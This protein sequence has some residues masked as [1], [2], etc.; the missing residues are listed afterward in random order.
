M[1]SF[2]FLLSFSCRICKLLHLGVASLL[3]RKN[4]KKETFNEILKGNDH[5]PYCK[6]RNIRS[7]DWHLKHTSKSRESIPLKRF[8]N[9]SLPCLL[10]SGAGCW[11]FSNYKISILLKKYCDISPKFRFCSVNKQ[12]YDVYDIKIKRN[13]AVFRQK[14]R[15]FGEILYGVDNIS[16]KFWLFWRNM[17]KF[18][19]I[20]I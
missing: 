9:E 1:C 6:C 4:L 3:W 8:F 19:L 10:R 15:H 11:S 5:A 20:L 12:G 18:R 7:I 16:P 17:A 14:I 2:A 13:F